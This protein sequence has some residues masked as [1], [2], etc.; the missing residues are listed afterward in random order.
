MDWK[1]KYLNQIVCI[2]C[3]EG[4]K[5]LPNNSIDLVLTDL[6]YALNYPYLSYSDTHENLLLLIKK[7]LPEMLRISKLC[8]IFCGVQ[9]ISLYPQSS[10]VMCYTW[11]TTAT[12]GEMGY[13]QWQPIL[14]YGKDIDGFGSVNNELKSDTIKLSGGATIG[15]LSKFP[16]GK[17]PCPKPQIIMDILTRRLSNEND[18][19][20]DPFIGSGTTAIACIKTN[21]NYIG[22]EISQEYVDMAN[23]RIKQELSQ[24]KLAL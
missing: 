22:M 6:P 12:Y 3:L 8:A 18:I 7:S 11:N 24:L 13:N 1:K 4:M 14:I 16:K 17:H 21:R 10:W 5:E 23:K 20:L 2:E 19:V 15:F 9:N